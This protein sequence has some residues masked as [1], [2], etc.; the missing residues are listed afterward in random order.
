MIVHILNDRAEHRRAA[1][2]A[3]WELLTRDLADDLVDRD[4][5]RTSPEELARRAAALGHDPGREHR[6][7]ALRWTRPAD[8]DFADKL[9]T[10]ALALRMTC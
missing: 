9:L 1:C 6:V 5:K 8:G 7:V 3:N 4:A 10:T 2:A